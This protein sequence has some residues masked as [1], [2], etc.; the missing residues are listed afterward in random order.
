LPIRTVLT[1]GETHHN[2]QVAGSFLGVAL[3]SSIRPCCGTSG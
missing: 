3:L 2:D 1:P